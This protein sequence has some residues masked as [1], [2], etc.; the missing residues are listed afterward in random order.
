M[1]PTYAELVQESDYILSIVP[2]RDAI[3]TAEAIG[4]A[5]ASLSEDKQVYYLDLNAVSPRTARH[6]ATILSSIKQIQFLDGGILGGVPYVK[7]SGEWHCP[8]LIISGPTRIPSGEVSKHLRIHHLNDTIGA[9]T[10]L[11]ICFGMNTK[12]FTALAIQSFTTAHKLGV[13]PEMREYLKRDFPE[14]LKAAE[15]GLTTMP[16]KAYRW[17]HEMLEMADTVSEDGGFEKNLSVL[18]DD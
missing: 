11:K 8:S 6:V 17:V 5:A 10:G 15:K 14:T 16:P 9:A 4:S 3:K 18:P 1:L 7:P 12:G 2:P 13:L